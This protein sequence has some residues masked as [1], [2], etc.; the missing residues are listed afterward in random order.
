MKQVT[1]VVP[2]GNVNLS[3]ITGSFEILTRA[4]EHWRSMGNQPKIEVRIAGLVKELKLD[5][6]FFSIYPINIS[7]IKKTD[8]VIIPSFYYDEHL[9]EDNQRLINWIG[10]QYKG[11]AEIASICSGVF[12][13]AASGLLDGKICST[14][15][16]AAAN[17]RRMF[18]HINLQTDKLITVE[19]GIYTNGGGYSFLNLILLLVEKYFNRE[20]AIFCSKLFQ[21]DIERHSQS[22][23]H[24]FQTQKNHGDELISRA[25]T[26]IEENLS[27]KISFE[28]L[29][30]KLAISRRNFD[31]RFNKATGNT[32]VEYLQ[33][34]KVEVAKSTLEKGR[35]SVFEVMSEVGYSDDKAFREVFKKITGLSPLEYRSKY[36][37]EVAMVSQ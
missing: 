3:S 11:G 16:N 4:N 5:L 2:N 31:R 28:E 9:I 7:D 18:P 12:L 25:Q 24:I 29:A 33:R 10:E 17:F 22:P 6:G 32:P 13:L 36:S 34:V 19:K 21:I 27:E 15:W 1:I 23:F 37:K 14:H 26:Y 35:K 8:L 30:S 20:I